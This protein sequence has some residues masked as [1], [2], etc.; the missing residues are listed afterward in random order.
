MAK[1]KIVFVSFDED[2][3]SNIEYKFARFF[4]KSASIE[5]ISDQGSF[6]R[7]MNLPR[8]TDIMILPEGT[9][10]SHPDAYSKTKI[11]YLSDEESNGNKPEY[12]YK[13]ASVKMMAEKIGAEF[14]SGKNIDDAR[15]TRLVGVF[16]VAGGTGKTLASLALASKLKKAGKRVMYISTVPHQDFAYYI[17]YDGTLGSSFC[18]QCSINMKNALKTI[19]GEIKN[20]GFDFLPPFRNLPVSYQ[21]FF[22]TYVQIVDFLKARNSYDYIIVEMSPELLPGKMRFIKECDKLVV[23]T[24]QDEIAVRQ[25]EAFIDSMSSDESE[26]LLVC[27]RYNS[28]RRNYLAESFISR[29]NE[30]VEYIYEYGK[31]L[32]YEGVKNSI[33]Y[34]KTAQLLD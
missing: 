26:M 13:Y 1:K 21:V 18:Y 15:G 7:L 32:N 24:T 22:D 17:D 23:L 25:L 3:I 16:S 33:L 14:I 4:E 27:N 34:D 19:D 6:K 28:R 10:I 20:E 8:K 12:I 31:T 11:F 30:V 29:N 9:M 5:F 2:Y